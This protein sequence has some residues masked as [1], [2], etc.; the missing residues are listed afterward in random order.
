M[1]GALSAVLRAP[2]G[3]AF[4][5]VEVLYRRDLE[6][7]ALIPAFVASVIA[8]AVTAPAL[9]YGGVM[10]KLELGPE[11][12]YSIEALALYALLGLVMA[13]PAMAYSIALSR[14][15]DSVS[16]A[17]LGAAG[18]AALALAAGASV[19]ALGLVFP[20]V[21]GSGVDYVSRLI[22]DL[23]RGEAPPIGDMAAAAAAKAAAT[24]ATLASGA[25]VGVFAP[26]L[27]I[28]CLLGGV[29]GEVAYRFERLVPPEAFAYI[30]MAAFLGGVAKTPLS[31]SIIVAEMGGNYHLL[32]P[33][34][35]SAVIA[36]T[37]SGP[38]SMYRGQPE[39]RLEPGVVG[40]QC[41]SRS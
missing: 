39:R 40:L 22:E 41:C 13:A 4:F 2:V 15:V 3:A 20:E 26:S 18:R 29:F 32:A 17:R 14:V 12:L 21:L 7:E 28:G 33:S 23:S 1:A 27:M 30:G 25:P 9:G 6:A 38:R 16:G 37:L 5:A 36:S 34:L 10:P 31:A 11:S 19:G 8:F 24:I 35:L